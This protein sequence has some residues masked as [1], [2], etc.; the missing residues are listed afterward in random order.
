MHVH[1]ANVSR[2]HPAQGKRSGSAMVV[3]PQAADKRD[4]LGNHEFFRGLPASIIQRLASHAR[5][6]HCPAGRRIFSKGDEGHGLLAVLSGVVKISVPSEDGKEIVLNLIG[7]NEIFGEVALLDGGARTADATALSDCELLVLDRRDVLPIIME[8][9]IVSLKLL[10]VVS[11]RLRRTTQQVEDLSFGDLSVRLAKAL[12]RLAQ[13]QG[14]IGHARPHVT[15]TQKELGHTIGLSRERT[16]WY[17]RAW[18]KAGHLT[19]EKGGC[20]INSKD[21]VSE[22][23]ESD[24]I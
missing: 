24:S 17:L 23:A 14:T 12:L 3:Q 8:E 16:N 10:E 19:L 2:Y 5:Q 18:E 15:I 9:P 22:L 7:A 4:I 6:S 11:S 1:E 13:L 21:L 20:V